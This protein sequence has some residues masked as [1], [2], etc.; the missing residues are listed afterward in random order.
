MSAVTAAMICG[1]P[2]SGKT[3]KALDLARQAALLTGFPILALDPGRVA[4]LE[5]IPEAESFREL[6][7]SVWDRGVHSRIC[8]E[9]EASW[10]RVWQAVRRLGRCI[11]L[12]DEAR[13]FVNAFK[14]SLP[15][16]QATRILNH[17]QVSLILTTQSYGDIPRSL[18]SVAT[19]LW[20]FRCTAP[21][22]L[23][24]LREDHGLDPAE[25]AALPKWSFKYVKVGF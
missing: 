9:S 15:A 21:R 10:D 11:V 17:L 20:V 6:V 4:Q 16:V 7:Y 24:R 23:E 8:P 18:S 1:C 14:L 3:T 25:V 19:E 5:D 2:Q 12:V 22:D 13:F